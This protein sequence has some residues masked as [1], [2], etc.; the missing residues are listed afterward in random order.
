MNPAATPSSYGFESPSSIKQKLTTATVLGLVA[1]L[2]IQFD[3][4]PVGKLGE[5]TFPEPVRNTVMATVALPKSDVSVRFSER[6]RKKEVGLGL[7]PG[8]CFA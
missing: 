6:L 4:E 3:I 7:G 8:S 5:W 2:I 1:R